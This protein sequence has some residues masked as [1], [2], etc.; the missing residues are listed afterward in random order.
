MRKRGS[1]PKGKV[2]IKWSADFAY[3]IGLI[4]SD[5]CLSRNGR[6]II[7]TSKNKDQIENFLKALSIKVFIGNNWSGSKNLSYRVQFSDKFFWN[8]LNSIVLMPNKSKVIEKVNIPKNY[9][10]DFLR[11]LFDGDGSIYS[12]FDKRWRSS[13]LFYISF[14]SASINFIS[15]LQKEIYELIKIK[16]HISH[17]QNTSWFQLKFAKN[18]SI[19]IIKKMYYKK[20]I[21]YLFRKKLKI[22]KILATM[23][24]IKNKF[25]LLKDRYYL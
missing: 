12:Y 9:F 19:L 13:F 23:L 4:T 3:A 5:G 18:E 24:K 21:I 8:F 14:V 1:K 11:G 20:S 6:N 25:R 17:S 7:F 2:K 15:W 10:F 16:G 22:D